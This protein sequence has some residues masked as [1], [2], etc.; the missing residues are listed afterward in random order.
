MSE[1]SPTR[2]LAEEGA[3]ASRAINDTIKRL[4]AGGAN[5]LMDGFPNYLQAAQEYN[6][7]MLEYTVAN[8]MAMF[9]YVRKLSETKTTPELVELT[10]SSCA[11]AIRDADS[12]SERASD[13]C[14]KSHAKARGNELIPAA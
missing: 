6:A 14:S 2:T 7:K 1:P 9:E 8:T 5:P 13:N 10:T 12:A 11:H 4:T 3:R